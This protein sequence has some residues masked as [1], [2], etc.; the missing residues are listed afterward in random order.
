MNDSL[1]KIN[2]A[3][4]ADFVRYLFAKLQVKQL[5]EEIE[6][7][8]KTIQFKDNTIIF[9]KGEN[10]KLSRIAEGKYPKYNRLV[11]YKKQIDGLCKALEKR[12]NRIEELEKTNEKLLIEITKAR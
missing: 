4:Q 6:K 3:E 10:I 8:E 5:K 1:I 7:L 9:Y 2:T 11:N 12:N